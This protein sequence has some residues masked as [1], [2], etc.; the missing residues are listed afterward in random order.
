MKAFLWYKNLPDTTKTERCS[1]LRTTLVGSAGCANNVR[2]H[3]NMIITK[4][5]DVDVSGS[6]NGTMLSLVL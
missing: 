4:I 1:I 6:P 5:W 2:T 3:L